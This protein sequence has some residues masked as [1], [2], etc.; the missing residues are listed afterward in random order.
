MSG[1]LQYWERARA[2]LE[3]PRVTSSTALLVLLVLS[4]YSDGGERPIWPSLRTLSAK[5]RLNE[6]TI[7]RA[8]VNLTEAGVIEA[9]ARPIGRPVR[10]RIVWI[11]L[12]AGGETVSRQS[13]G[14]E[15]A[16][17][18]ADSL[19]ALDGATADRESGLPGQRIQPTPD[20][21]SGGP[22]RGSGGPVIESAD[23]FRN[24]SE[25]DPNERTNERA[26]AGQLIDLSCLERVL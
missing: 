23:R 20:R 14:E 10:Y 3:S 18:T 16:S 22:D 17:E 8:L 4:D 19:S 1:R 26:R 11:S 15:T 25:I 24:G 9:I 2:I 21:G 13:S 5:T 12:S 7:R 6:R